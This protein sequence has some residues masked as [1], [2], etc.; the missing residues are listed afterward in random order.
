[1]PAKNH[2]LGNMAKIKSCNYLPNVLMK[3]EA[4][5]RNLDYVIGV[6]IEGNLTESATENIL[7]VDQTGTLI[8][9]E[10]DSILKGTTMIRVCQLAKENAIPT[11]VRSFSIKDLISAREV[12][13]TG[14]SL[15]VLPV[16]K[17]EADIIGN[18]TPGPIAQKL[19]ELMQ[20]DIKR[21]LNKPLENF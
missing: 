11:Q 4:I 8:H 3:K 2:E 1:M 9:P 15:N 18:G 6:D 7:I 19:N 20:A 13:I 10:L 12:L 17:F 14:T 21:K 16:V 5:D